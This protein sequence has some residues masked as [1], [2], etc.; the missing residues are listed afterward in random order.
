MKNP[1]NNICHTVS[2]ANSGLYSLIV[3]KVGTCAKVH[4]T[5]EI[6]SLQ[7]F[8][9][10]DSGN[11]MTI[12]KLQL[13]STE[14][15]EKPVLLRTWSYVNFIARYQLTLLI[16]RCF[17]YSESFSFTDFQISGCFWY[18][19]FQTWYAIRLL[20]KGILTNCN[21]WESSLSLLNN[22]VPLP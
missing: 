4:D 19:S 12:Y 18:E 16:R 6:G 17:L 10:H 2:V 3:R 20:I 15:C 9:L 11:D 22:R 1:G 14:T 7:V 13:C 5:E 21:D 8:S